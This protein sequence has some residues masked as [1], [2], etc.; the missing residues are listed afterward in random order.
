MLV[1][2]CGRVECGSAHRRSVAVLCMLY[3]IRCNPVHPLNGALPDRMCQCRLHAVLWSHIGTLMFFLAE[4]PHS[5][6]GLV[7][8]SQCPSGTI[9]L[10]P[11][12]MVWDWRASRAGSMLFIGLSCSIPTIVFYYFS[13]SLL[14]VYG[15]VLLL[16]GVFGL[17]ECLSLSLSHALPTLFNN[18]NE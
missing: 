5:I 8:P 14:S 17:I 13:L 4:D 7:F 9:L 12:S 6:A 16:A 18:N 11:Y 3:T 1:S 10:I 15:L 2:N